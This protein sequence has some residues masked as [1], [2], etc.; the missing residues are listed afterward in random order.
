ME[1]WVPKLEIAGLALAPILLL[2]LVF[3]RIRFRPLVGV[4]ARTTTMLATV[5][6]LFFSLF[7]LSA[8]GCEEDRE[9]IGSPDGRHVARMMIWGSVPTGSSLRIVERRSWS[10]F[11]RTV[12]RAGSVG[13]PLEPIEPK[14]I[15]LDN[16]HLLLDYPESVDGTGSDCTSRRVG[17]VEL[18]CRTHEFH[19]GISNSSKSLHSTP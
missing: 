16:I 10:P 3:R 17:D 1:L 14:V 9:L 4:A 7:L 11:W 12:S 19:D 5:L 2:W 6:C 18:V 13:T 8:Q 15:W